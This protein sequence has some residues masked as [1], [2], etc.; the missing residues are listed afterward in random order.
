MLYNTKEL[1][2]VAS[3]AGRVTI[4]TT[5]VAVA[6][7]VT[8]FIFDTGG[9]HIGKSVHATGTATTTLTVLNTPPAFTV[10]AYE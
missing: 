9:N 6:V 4:L 8:A 1:P 7:F 5:L 2:N 10:N 3:T